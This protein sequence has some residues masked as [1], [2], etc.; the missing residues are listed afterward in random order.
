[1][2]PPPRRRGGRSILPWLLCVVFGAGWYFASHPDHLPFGN[3]LRRGGVAR[4]ARERLLDQWAA[5]GFDSTAYGRR[6]LAA[7]DSALA[8]PQPTQLPLALRAYFGGEPAATAWG[9]R[10]AAGQSLPIE[11]TATLLDGE[12][13]VELYRRD[14]GPDSTRLVFLRTLTLGADTLAA[15]AESDRELL[16][17][18]EATPLAQ[19]NVR[20]RIGTSPALGVFPVEGAGLREVQSRWGASRD[21]GRRR[22]EGID[23]F[24]PRGT[25]LLAAG[26][27][28]VTR[29]RER[30]LGGRQVWLRLSGAPVSLYYAHLDEWRVAAGARVSA[31]D[32]LG[33]LGNSG[34]ARTTPPHL[35]FGI[36][37][38]GGAI[39]P[40][41]FVTAAEVAPR[42]LGAEL[43]RDAPARLTR[44]AGS[45]GMRLPAKLF[46]RP[47]ATANAQTYVSL[48]DGTLRSIATALLE[49]ATE[50]TSRERLGAGVPLLAS[51]TT[52]A[53]AIDSLAA[54]EV[55]QVLA[56]A[57]PGNTTTRYVQTSAGRR[58]WLL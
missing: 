18:V 29:V 37:T 42:P 22:H 19:G 7:G 33:T 24:R 50:P 40:L 25:P 39:D 5:V 31:G 10:V 2:Y 44:A 3:L 27:G 57:G 52:G 51:P 6:W 48:P 35:H 38:R 47:L 34:N 56:K 21:G 58:G 13:L 45:G 30:G 11:V 53:P 54:G 28:V 43:T 16:L 41:P 49:P 15:D 55:V 8:A 36:Y 20:V 46:A 4:T 26:P 9:F 12:P 1:M 17:R 32:T 23:I 14:R